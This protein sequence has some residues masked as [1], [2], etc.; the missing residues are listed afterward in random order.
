MKTP[1]KTTACKQAL[2]ETS[3]VFRFGGRFQFRYYD[4]HVKAWRESTTADYWTTT[5]H[6]RRHLIE[7][8]REIMHPE[9]EDGHQ[10]ESGD[11]VGGKW[12]S[13]V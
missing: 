9:L 11:L 10:Y 2:A 6:R 5:S 4:H 12:E 7:R 3:T 8:A 13:Y 1:T